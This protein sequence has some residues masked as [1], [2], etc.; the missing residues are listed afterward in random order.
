MTLPVRKKGDVNLT[1]V[2]KFR[3]ND[4]GEMTLPVRKKVMLSGKN[5]TRGKKDGD[6]TETKTFCPSYFFLFS[7]KCIQHQ[8]C[9]N[10]FTCQKW[11]E[12]Q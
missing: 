10:W 2:E 11:L 6:K 8:P 3:W 12:L 4:F 1:F 5:E 7:Q 9:S